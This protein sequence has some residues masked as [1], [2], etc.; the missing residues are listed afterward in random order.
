M[1]SLTVEERKLRF[2]S[3]TVVHVI[4]VFDFSFVFVTFLFIHFP[5]NNRTWPI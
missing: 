2:S 1:I 4:A 5:W 3:F